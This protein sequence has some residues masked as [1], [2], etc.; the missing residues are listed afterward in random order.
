[1]MRTRRPAPPGVPDRTMKPLRLAC[2]LLCCWTPALLP[3]GAAT[4]TSA[5]Q[6]ASSRLD[7]VTRVLE[8]PPASDY[9]EAVVDLFDTVMQVTGLL[10]LCGEVAPDLQKANEAA[11]NVWRESPSSV[12]VVEAH[13][14]A[15]ILKNAGGQDALARQVEARWLA[16]SVASN[17]RFYADQPNTAVPDM[18]QAFAG[19][20]QG[21]FNLDAQHTDALARLRSR[22]LP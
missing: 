2:L 8:M 5:P 17:K 12:Q 10:A 6:L 21:T 20:L 9:E 7:D 16:E 19:L 18:C 14:R 3:A 4:S 22:P 1:M 11:F 15:L 13:A